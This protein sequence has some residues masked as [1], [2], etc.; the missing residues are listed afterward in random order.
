MQWKGRPTDTDTVRTT[1]HWEMS[2]MEVSTH[3]VPLPIRLPILLTLA[4]RDLGPLQVPAHDKTGRPQSTNHQHT[5][6][7]MLRR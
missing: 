7:T 2:G 1:P 3:H 5:A 6:V 4:G